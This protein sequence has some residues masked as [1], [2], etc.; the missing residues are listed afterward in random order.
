MDSLK[1][2]F[3][4]DRFNFTKVKSGEIICEIYNTDDQSEGKVRYSFK[5]CQK[6]LNLGVFFDFM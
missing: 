5:I 2:R 4:P 6:L 1:M 3:D